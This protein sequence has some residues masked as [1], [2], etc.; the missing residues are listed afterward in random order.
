MLNSRS[1][2]YRNPPPLPDIKWERVADRPGEGVKYRIEEVLAKTR[3]DELNKVYN[4][5]RQI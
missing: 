1:I 3:R 5:K 2:G 4:L